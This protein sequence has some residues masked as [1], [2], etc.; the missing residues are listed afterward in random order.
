MKKLSKLIVLALSVALAMVFASCETEV[1]KI[2]T[3]EVEKIVEVEKTYASPVTFTSSE[4]DD[5]T[6]TVEM[7]TETS[8]AEIY[9]TTTGATPTTDSKKYEEA[10]T[11]SGYAVIAAIAVKSGLENSPVS[12]A[13]IPLTNN[14]TRDS[15]SEV[16]HYK[17]TL[18]G[19]Y[20]LYT[21]ASDGVKYLDS[22]GNEVSVTS[23]AA[24]ETE[25]K[26]V[27]SGTKLSDIAKTIPGFT[28]TN[29]IVTT[30]SNDKK[31]ANVYY[32][33]NF[34]SLKIKAEDGTSFSLGT[35]PFGTTANFNF[36]DINKTLES[37][38]K[39]IKTC[40][41]L[42]LTYP[43]EDTSYTIT[44]GAKTVSNDGLV[45]INKG[46][47]NM[48]CSKKDVNATYVP[49]PVHSV[50]ITRDFY[51]SDHETTQ[52]EFCDLMNVTQE[53]LIESAKTKGF[54]TNAKDYGSGDDYPV[55]YVSWYAAIAYCN[56][57][58]I[59]NNLDLAYSVKADGSELD[60]ASL[61]F[62]DVP[63]TSDES[64]NAVTL[65]LSKN[66]YRLPT[67]S[68][69]EYAAR[70]GNTSTDTNIWSGDATT[71]DELKNYAWISTNSDSLQHKIRSKLPNAYGLYDMTGNSWEWCYDWYGDYM[72][73]T[74]TTVND[75]TGAESGTY[76]SMRGSFFQNYNCITHRQ[77][78]SLPYKAL[79]SYSFRV[80]RT[81]SAE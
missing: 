65:D 64:W 22:S 25:V 68:E 78:D 28:A 36:E 52:K 72:G 7:A 9:Y 15:A 58:S 67:E 51:M 20:T 38:G 46:T 63:T 24:S 34:I 42:P 21:Y 59:K 75:P 40:E 74:N 5:G 26:E 55:Y 17:K 27:A 80:V 76:R 49:S 71:T 48:G 11:V 19:T 6:T 62:S 77:P 44:L 32:E 16:H 61:A 43:S 37:Q 69:W 30:D 3:Q 29:V 8:G 33:R 14:V 53:E 35:E 66:G 81:A 39:F 70:A 12:Y 23:S 13:S 50:T 54:D 1:E 45:K 60:W 4:N 31:I 57:L 47:F 56:K 2:V 73:D 79:R 18:S 10:I 41:S